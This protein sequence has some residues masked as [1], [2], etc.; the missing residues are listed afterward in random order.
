MSFRALQSNTETGGFRPLT[1]PLQSSS[2]GFP[3]LTDSGVGSIPVIKQATELGAGIG[4][5]IGKTGLNVG[6]SFFNLAQGISNVG[7]KIFGGQA[8][9]YSSLIQGIDTISNNIFQKPFEKELGTLSGKTGNIIGAAA[10][11]VASGGAIADVANAAS[12]AVAGSGAVARTLAGAGTE[13]LANFG[14]GYALSG[15]NTKEATIQGVT[16]GVLKGGTAGVGELANKIKFPESMVGKVF[17]TDKREVM[18]IFKTGNEET[19]AKQVLDRGISGT[20]KQI[21]SQLLNGAA[22]SEAAISD[23]FIKAGN[24][25]IYLEDPKRFI[26][27]IADKAALLRKSGAIQEAKGLEASLPAINPETGAITANNSLSLRRFLDG[28]RTEKSFVTPTE[29][30]T[31]Q[32][33]GL[34]E[35]ADEIRHKINAI[36]GVSPIM[37]DYQFYIKALDKLAG[38]AVRTK[39]NDAVGIINSFL[40]GE[41]IAATNPYLGATAIGRKLLQTTY[42]TTKSAQSLKNLPSSGATGAAVRSATGALIGRKQ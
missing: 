29:E 9:D 26:D 38:H 30:T 40:L 24:P 19:L 32:Q 3:S 35:M 42:G 28:L 33:A 31:A 15:G 4:T 13:A 23:E 34:K 22:K 12:K 27:Y 25:L 1:I 2:T 18:N 11:Y 16:A 21:A 41:S 37:K 17:K 39:N 36:G 20:T 7:S 6:K 5:A 14:Q 10:P 8:A